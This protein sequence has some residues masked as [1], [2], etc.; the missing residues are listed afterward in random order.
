MSID[1]SSHLTLHEKLKTDASAGASSVKN[2]VISSDTTQ[3]IR[4]DFDQCL[5]E[6]TQKLKLRQLIDS[7]DRSILG[8]VTSTLDSEDAAA[9][10]LL[11][12]GADRVVGQL[13]NGHLS[14]IVMTKADDM[15]DIDDSLDSSTA[16]MLTDTSA[17]TLAQNLE[18]IMERLNQLGS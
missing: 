11:G 13:L 4:S 17:E 7:L 6:E 8:N 18:T 10:L 16:Q 3:T 5:K 9:Q 2:T 14:S 12:E 1:I 15:E